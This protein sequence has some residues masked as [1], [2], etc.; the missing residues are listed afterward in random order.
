MGTNDLVELNNILRFH[1]RGQNGVNIDPLPLLFDRIQRHRPRDIDLN[2]AVG[3][4]DGEM[5]FCAIVPTPCRSWIRRPPMR[6]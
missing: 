4:V 2:L 1:K 6:T 3:P 5:D